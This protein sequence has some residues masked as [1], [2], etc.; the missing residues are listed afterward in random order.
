MGD[1]APEL[2]HGGVTKQQVQTEVERQL[3]RAGV[4]VLS[5]QEAGASPDIAF[6]TV[7]VTTL[8]HD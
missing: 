8:R 2:E 4:P 3:R 7:S 5:S 1:V 6:L